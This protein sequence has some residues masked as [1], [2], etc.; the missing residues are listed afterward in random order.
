MKRCHCKSNIFLCTS[1]KHALTKKLKSDNPNRQQTRKTPTRERKRDRYLQ[2]SY[3]YHLSPRCHRDFPRGPVG[4]CLHRCC[5]EM[6]C[7]KK[8]DYTRSM[9]LSQP[10]QLYCQS[11]TRPMQV[12]E[13]PDGYTHFTFYSPQK[14]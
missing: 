1:G 2:I 9:Y 13:S 8:A 12:N 7:K 5:H 3:Q 14:F 11:T 6:S 4:R 10:D